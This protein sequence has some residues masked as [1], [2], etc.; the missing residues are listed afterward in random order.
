MP[1]SFVKFFKIYTL[2]SSVYSQLF[3]YGTIHLSRLELAVILGYGEFRCHSNI[4]W[5]LGK[6]VVHVESSFGKSRQ[7]GLVLGLI[8]VGCGQHFLVK[9]GILLL[10][11][12]FYWS[13]GKL[14]GYLQLHLRCGISFWLFGKVSFNS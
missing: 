8:Q 9:F 4:V 14:E 1:Q 13:N 5:F 3:G 10:I 2:L 11:W 12:R 7:Y 6:F